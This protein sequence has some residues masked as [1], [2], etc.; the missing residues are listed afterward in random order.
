MLDRAVMRLHESAVS[1]RL[2]ERQIPPALHRKPPL[3]LGTQKPHEVQLCQP[4]LGLFAR[5][6]H[7]PSRF[8][9]ASSHLILLCLAENFPK[10]CLT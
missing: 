6:V 10:F 1:V 3:F 7:F 4:A 2:R 8:S 9:E 5:L